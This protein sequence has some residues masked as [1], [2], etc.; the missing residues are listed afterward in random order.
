MHS[1]AVYN[2]GHVLLGVIEG[3]QAFCCCTVHYLWYFANVTC[4]RSYFGST[5]AAPLLKYDF[6]FS[7]NEPGIHNETKAR[8]WEQQG[9][10]LWLSG[11]PSYHCRG[12]DTVGKLFVCGTGCR[13]WGNSSSALQGWATMELITGDALNIVRSWSAAA[14][15]TLAPL[16]PVYF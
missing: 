11:N 2:K 10:G 13:P 5:K 6:L 9:F 3:A 4:S 1:V 15:L 14:R 16:A 12:R 8:L 7:V